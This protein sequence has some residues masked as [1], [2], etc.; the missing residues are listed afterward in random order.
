MGKVTEILR[1][2]EEPAKEYT[3]IPFW[4]FNDRPDEKKIREQLEDYVEKGVHGFVLHPRIGIPKDLPYLSEAYFDVVKYI[5]RTADELDMKVVLYDEGMYPSG[6]AHGMVVAQNPEFASKG[7]T[8][9][10]KPEGISVIARLSDG[11]YLVEDFTGGTIR[12]IHFGEDDGEE[13]APPS[14]DILNPQVTAC[15]IHLTHDRYYAHLKEYFGN[16]IIGFFTDEPCALGRN[17]GNFREW[18]A[19]ME[20]E[21]TAAGGKLEELESLFRG[22]ENETTRIYRRLIKK[23]L[24][25]NFYAPLS[26]WCVAHGI[27]FMGHPAESDDVEEAFCFQVPGQDLILRR[28]TP[29][30]G[31]LEG[32]DSV[33]A[34]LSADIARHL[35]R[36]RNAN[37]CFGVCNRNQIPWYFTGEDMKW[38]LDWMA[39]RGV[40]LFIPHAFYYSVEGERKGERPPDVGPNNIWWEHYRLF[41]DYMKRMA[42]LMTDSV[43]RAKVAVLC[44]NNRVPYKEVAPLYEEQIDFHYLPVAFLEKC[45]VEKGALCIRDS[46][47]DVILDVGAFLEGESFRGVPIVRSVG[48]ILQMAEEGR[49]VRTVSAGERLEKLRAVRLEKEGVE[50]FLL[51]NEGAE[52]ISADVWIPCGEGLVRM[53]LW[54]GKFGAAKGVADGEGTRVALVLEPCET[55]LFLADPMGEVKETF[56]EE[57][58]AEN[59]DERFRLVEKKG[60][61]ARYL[62]EFEG[63]ACEG[64][65]VFEV[66]GEEMVECY[67]NG[68]FVG[69]SFW[70]RHR[71]EVG[72]VWKKGRNRV[73]VVVT[74]SAANVYGGMGIWFGLGE[75]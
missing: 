14:A 22:E 28:V 64:R 63:E 24:R 37:E 8:M 19:G 55:V 70:G 30:S 65:K 38:Y 74:G 73:E 69:V 68:E 61:Q 75:E 57:V 54:N 11:R 62:Y 51:C 12:G 46:A 42:Y 43:N 72:E 7:I 40:N 16:T 3:P 41:S 18:A 1:Q 47:Y 4:F 59:W 15:F 13:G 2:I 66:T 35:G 53:D 9:R 34:K 71:F 5:V 45:R 21:L 60:N 10:E 49:I 67:W 52:T 36:R 32:M 56:P 33:Q 31:G 27:V 58:C 26:A 25:E 48:E 23:K 6:S 29:M 39:M 20:T 44:G 50:M 17:A